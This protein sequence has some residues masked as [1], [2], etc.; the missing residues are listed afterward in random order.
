MTVTSP[1][2]VPAG[3]AFD[4]D[5]L[6]YF[7]DMGRRPV[8]DVLAEI[9]LIVTGPHASAAFPEE[10]APFV[11]DRLTCRLQHDF[12]DISTSP[13]ARRWAEIDPHVL[14][15]ENPHPRAVRD[16]N[17]ARP[18]D[19]GADLREAFERLRR[20]GETERPSLDGVDAIRPVTFGYL[21]VL[22][23]P[24]SDD[25]WDEMIDALTKAGSL[26]VDVYE[27]VRDELIER[28]IN[29]KLARLTSLEPADVTVSEWR[30]ASTLL[31]VSLHD[32]MN[33]TARS[34]GAI[35][36]EREP[37]D[38]LPNVI[39]HSNHGGPDAAVRGSTTG[40]LLDDEDVLSLDPTT[41]RAIANAYRWAFDAYGPDDVA[42]NRPY[43]GGFETR[44]IA[45]WLRSRAGNAVVSCD[46]LPVELHLGAW[47]IEFLREFLLGPAATEHLIAPGEDW[48]MPPDDH[49]NWVAER[50]RAAHDR[51]RRWGPALA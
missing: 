3:T 32:T 4:A 5:D 44:H 37:V 23:K 12:T 9:D 30:S 14:Y 26:G 34:D 17:R 1:Q 15:V 11:V 45:P 18:A 43:L 35:C 27:R 6:V 16:A 8:D 41:M 28:T 22:R 51:M 48:V 29:A 21:P 38:R 46:G 7:H 39:A 36:V 10:M 49:V 42:F 40:A 20:A 33:Y 2:W 13:V 47:Q 50:L 24:Q 31:V 25:Q 19:L